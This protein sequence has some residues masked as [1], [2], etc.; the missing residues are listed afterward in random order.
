MARVWAAAEKE[1]GVVEVGA[2]GGGCGEGHMRP[3]IAA[4]RKDMRL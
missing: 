4:A 2:K 3:V 1:G